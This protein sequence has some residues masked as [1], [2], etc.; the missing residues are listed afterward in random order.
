MF[1][2]VQAGD[3]VLVVWDDLGSNA[4]MFQAAVTSLK[5]AAG[6]LW[7]IRDRDTQEQPIRSL[8]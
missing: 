7:P 1:E 6:E 3:S 8:C 2:S 5:E 4:D